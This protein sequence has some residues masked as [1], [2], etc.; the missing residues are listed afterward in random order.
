MHLSSPPNEVRSNSKY[1]WLQLFLSIATLIWEDWDLSLRVIASIVYLNWLKVFT[2]ILL[3]SIYPL[4]DFKVSSFSTKRCISVDPW[5]LIARANPLNIG[6]YW[7]IP[8]ALKL[9][10][11]LTSSTLLINIAYTPWNLSDFWSSGVYGSDI[12][13]TYLTLSI[14]PL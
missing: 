12:S 13:N 9:S 10:S 6:S 3:S 2:W 8:R 11:Q 4:T 14:G 1:F 7:W 5:V